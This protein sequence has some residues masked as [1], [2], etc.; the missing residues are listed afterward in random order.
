MCLFS[1]CDFAVEC[2]EGHGDGWCGAVDAGW[3]L[4]LVLRMS[5]IA[6]RHEAAMGGEATPLL[7]KVVANAGGGC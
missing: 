4:G 2:A 5:G 1:C 6:G 3:W 7:A